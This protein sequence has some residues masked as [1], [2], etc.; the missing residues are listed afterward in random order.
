MLAKLCCQLHGFS[1]SFLLLHWCWCRQ[2]LSSSY[3]SDCFSV[4][5][6]D[7]QNPGKQKTTTTATDPPK[8]RNK[9]SHQYPPVRMQFS[10][11]GTHLGQSF[12][13]Q[14]SS[15]SVAYDDQASTEA[16]THNR[17]PI[18]LQMGG[19]RYIE[20]HSHLSRRGPSTGHDHHHLSLSQ[21]RVSLSFLHLRF[22]LVWFPS[23]VLFCLVWVFGFGFYLLGS[24]QFLS[25]D[26]SM[27]FAQLKLWKLGA[28]DLQQSA[29][30]IQG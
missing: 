14:L 3:S 25:L 27:L 17:N 22:F 30:S 10:E 8:R 6:H 5:S 23:W 2:Q 12:L 20:S 21:D 7:T 24:S 19:H 18:L 26:G 15:S 28:G 11:L 13:L 16:K 9:P 4:F 29:S 1:H